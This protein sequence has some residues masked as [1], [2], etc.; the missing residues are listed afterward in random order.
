MTTV[1]IT[2]WKWVRWF[3]PFLL[4]PL[5]RI[6][7]KERQQT[8]QKVSLLQIGT[9]P[10]VWVAF[11]SFHSLSF[12][13][14][15]SFHV[16]S[17][18]ESHMSALRSKTMY[19]SAFDEALSKPLITTQHDNLRQPNEKPNRRLSLQSYDIE[20]HG[21][22]SS[23]HDV[24]VSSHQPK[25][26]YHPPVEQSLLLLNDE[27]NS[28]SVVDSLLLRERHEETQNIHKNMS[29]IQEISTTLAQLIHS[30][31]HDIDIIEEN[32]IHVHENTEEALSMLE[33]AQLLLK[34]GLG[35]EEG[36]MRMFFLVIAVGGG[37]ISFVMLLESLL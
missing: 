12:L 30:Q 21:D 31:Q 20:N 26:V 6:Y 36:A 10:F 14:H 27:L 11:H 4:F 17:L 19:A 5:H 29:T 15:R 2:A 34:N 1:P 33:K 13:R 32:A 23:D 3:F 8:L 7:W 22:I 18:N 24:S 16:E 28:S 9:N 35:R 37:A 25:L